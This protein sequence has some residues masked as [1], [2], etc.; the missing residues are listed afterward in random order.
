LIAL[1]VLL[2]G[3]YGMVLLSRFPIDASSIRTFQF[4]LWKDMP[5]AGEPQAGH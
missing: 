5:G 2:P 4:F 1:S 3:Q